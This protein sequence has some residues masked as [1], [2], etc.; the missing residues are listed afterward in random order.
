MS[1]LFLG[2]SVKVEK[3]NTGKKRKPGPVG[4]HGLLVLPGEKGDQWLKIVMRNIKFQ[5]YTSSDGFGLNGAP[6]A[7][8]LPDK[9]DKIGE[10]GDRGP[11]GKFLKLKV[12]NALQVDISRC[13][14]N[15][16]PR[17]SSWNAR[18][19]RRK[20]RPWAKG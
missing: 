17:R 18:K 20:R 16:W 10:K 3:G 2:P 9:V 7:R 5:L 6:G 15:S 13:S 11:Q 12:I 8:R 14:R 19:E 1:E 4:V